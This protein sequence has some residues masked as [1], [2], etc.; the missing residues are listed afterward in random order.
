MMFFSPRRLLFCAAIVAAPILCPAQEVTLDG[1]LSGRAMPA[2]MKPADLPETYMAV[3]FGGDSQGGLM[4]M[5]M[6][7]M[8]MFGAMMGGMGG[9]KSDPAAAA[10]LEVMD[11][12]W[13]DGQTI[14]LAGQNFLVTYKVVMGMGE[15]MKMGDKPDF[16]A[17]QLRLTL[18]RTDQIKSLMPRPDI[19][20]AEFIKRL[21]AKIAIPKEDKP[22]SKDGGAARH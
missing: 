3:K 8:M 9:S 16:S 20:K 5:L 19:S 1:V 10:A 11:L 7:P 15:M 2:S 18:M 17:M 21:S 13:T 14:N 6:G 12:S 4:D 22:A